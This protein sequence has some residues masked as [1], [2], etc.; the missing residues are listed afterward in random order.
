MQSLFLPLGNKYHTA[1]DFT[2]YTHVTLYKQLKGKPFLI[3]RSWASNKLLTYPE[4]FF[5]TKSGKL[6]GHE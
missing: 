5:H 1:P 6:L 3:V 4:S 2:A